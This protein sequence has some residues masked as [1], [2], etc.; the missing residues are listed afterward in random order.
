MVVPMV[1]IQHLAMAEQV[2]GEV[3]RNKAVRRRMELR[4][5]D[6]V[7]RRVSWRK[8]LACKTL[9]GLAFKLVEASLPDKAA[10]IKRS[11]DMINVDIVAN[12]KI[13]EQDY[14][15]SDSFYFKAIA[16]PISCRILFH[17][18]SS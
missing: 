5:T 4:R 9:H 7:G 12:W 16:S 6:R 15:S 10:H 3:R 8:A 17:T 18:I 14:R 1:D 2:S 11:E 13:A